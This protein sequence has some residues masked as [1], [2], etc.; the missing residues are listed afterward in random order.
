MND[1]SPSS[2]RSRYPP[3]RPFKK[4]LLF[5]AG[6]AIALLLA[7]GALR[8]F[9][10]S[11]FNPY[12]VD[13]DVGFSLRPNAEGW[14]RKEGLTY[15]RINSQ[16]LRDREHTIVK[17]R[18][19]IRIAVL[20][21]SFAEAFQVPMEK[22]FWTVMEQKL[23]ECV[24]SRDM[25]TTPAMKIEA[26]NFG[27]SGFST[28]R[29][30]ILLRQRVWQ[31]SPDIVLLLVTTR[32]DIRD[33]SRA[34]DPYANTGLPY[35]VYRD[36]SLKLDDSRIQARNRS[37]SFRVQQSLVGRAL[38]QLRTHSRLM[39]LL[40]AAREAYAWRNTPKDQH[41]SYPAEPGLDDEVFRAPAN[42]DWVDAWNVT[43]KLIVQMR[44]EVSAR[45]AKFLV[46]TGSSGIQVSPD[47]S[48]S[49]AYM[50]Q[51]GVNTLF[52]PELRIKALGDREGFEVLNLAPLLL[53]YA[54]RNQIFLHGSGETN[55]RGHWNETGHRVAGELI[56][57]KL[58]QPEWLQPDHSRSL[59]GF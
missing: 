43:E 8:V 7:E 32:N 6:L 22:T 18:D 28:A 24:T 54:T 3:R 1:P 35:F 42:S 50:K 14:W 34:L 13:Q 2:A 27:V 12:I 45:G 58:C 31:Y 52:Y 20:G 59:S 51:L 4:L 29:E 10:F 44:N 21:D 38:N 41:D 23:Q 15:V 33:N 26:L 53:E 56:A 46:V 55:G 9:G 40:D 25:K 47:V 36:G 11:H 30:L 39:G 57:Q 16:G 48:L 17:P 37:F 19:T 5:I 49:A